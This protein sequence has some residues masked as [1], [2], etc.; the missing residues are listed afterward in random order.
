VLGIGFLGVLGMR[1]TYG[2]SLEYLEGQPVR[3]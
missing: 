1:E 3:D 2:I